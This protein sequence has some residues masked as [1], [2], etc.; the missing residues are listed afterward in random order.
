[1]N[2]RIQLTVGSKVSGKNVADSFLKLVYAHQPLK[3]SI[4]IKV[5]LV[6]GVWPRDVRHLVIVQLHAV[7]VACGSNWILRRTSSAV[8]TVE[9][10]LSI[11]RLNAVTRWCSLRLARILSLFLPCSG[12]VPLRA[13][14]SQYLPFLNK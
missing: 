10:S 14:T 12:Y 13:V 11:S 7:Q 1:M 4:P 8:P 3:A 6:L 5:S 9:G 2:P